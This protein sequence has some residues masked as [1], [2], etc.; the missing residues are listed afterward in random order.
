MEGDV[1]VLWRREGIPAYHLTSVVDD[2]EFGISHV[3]RG[4]DLRASTMIQR[5]LSRR[6]PGSTF[7]DTWVAHHRLLLD[8]TGTK[9]SKSSG[10][11]SVPLRMDAE[12][13][14][15]VERLATE[16][17]ERDIAPQI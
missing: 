12:T 13:K 14:A 9:L 10:R 11:H 4:E 17:W 8:H 6:I 3:I 15:E 5:E 7:F 2:D 1:I 16:L